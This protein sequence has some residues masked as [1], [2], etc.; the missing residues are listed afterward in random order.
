MNRTSRHFGGTLPKRVTVQGDRTPP[1]LAA[2]AHRDR[3]RRTPPTGRRTPGPRTLAADRRNDRVVTSQPDGHRTLRTACAAAD[4]H[5]NSWSLPHRPPKTMR[6]AVPGNC[7]SGR[8]EHRGHGGHHRADTPAA[9]AVADTAEPAAADAPARRRIR[10]DRGSGHRQA[11][12]AVCWSPGSSPVPARRLNATTPG[13]RGPARQ[14]VERRDQRGRRGLVRDATQAPYLAR[15]GR[16]VR[17]HYRTVMQL[18]IVPALAGSPPD[19]WMT[20]LSGS[21]L[22]RPGAVA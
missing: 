5:P 19:G 1:R 22:G 18:A 7:G 9:T 6:A 3:G 12:P 10:I 20:V 21:W 17:V 2:Q 8:G 4:G 16:G 11:P 15:S 14:R 13:G